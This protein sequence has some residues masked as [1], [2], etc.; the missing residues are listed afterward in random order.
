MMA[1]E[2]DMQMPPFAAQYFA[3]PADQLPKDLRKQVACLRRDT[4]EKLH[5]FIAMDTSGIVAGAKKRWKPY[6][7]T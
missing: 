2:N 1:V 5:I 7:N 4:I 3:W 6:I